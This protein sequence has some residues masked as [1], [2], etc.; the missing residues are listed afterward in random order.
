[1]PKLLHFPYFEQ[2]DAELE[3][4]RASDGQDPIPRLPS[5]GLNCRL[6]FVLV[7]VKLK[8]H[9]ESCSRCWGGNHDTKEENRDGE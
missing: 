6:R 3:T 4:L 1:M 2:L 8:L 7:S 9:L 5:H